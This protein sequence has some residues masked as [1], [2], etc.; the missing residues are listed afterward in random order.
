L[1]YIG[2]ED[3]RISSNSLA[4][5]NDIIKNKPKGPLNPSVSNKNL[6]SHQNT[7]Q[8]IFPISDN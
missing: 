3:N 2:L 6:I 7:Q 8:P 5:I 4:Q 1:K